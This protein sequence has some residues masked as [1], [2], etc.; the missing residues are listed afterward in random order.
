MTAPYG[1]KHDGTVWSAAFSPDGEQIITGDARTARVWSATTGIEIA[2][3]V[4]DDQVIS[5]AFRPDG[6]YALSGSWD[7]TVRIWMWQPEDLVTNTCAFLPRNLTGNEWNQYI[8]GAL[9]YQAVCPNLPIEPEVT[10]TALSS[11]TP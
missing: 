10:P 7:H 2:R 5:V 11:P 4:Y 1:L 8:G 6:N 9:P 3:M